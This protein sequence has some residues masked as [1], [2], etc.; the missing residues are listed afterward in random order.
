MD[1]VRLWG[2]KI[3][4]RVPVLG[5]LMRKIYSWNCPHQELFCADFPNP[6]GYSCTADSNGDFIEALSL[7]GAA[8]MEIGTITPSGHLDKRKVASK[9]LNEILHNLQKTPKSLIIAANI[10]KDVATGR[11]AAKY[12]YEKS[13][14]LLYD[15]VDMFVVNLEGQTP[16]ETIDLQDIDYLG[17]I[18][19]HLLSLRLYYDGYK[20]ILI[21]INH[22]AHDYAIQ[23]IL[24]Y[25]MKYGIDGVIAD[26]NKL[27]DTVALVKKIKAISG[28]ILPIVASGGV[29]HSSHAFSLIEAG[30]S[31]ISLNSAFH[32][33]GSHCIN[34]I[35]RGLYHRK[36][37]LL[38][39]YVEEDTLNDAID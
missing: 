13:F 16:Q 30:A 31:L 39:N 17:D 37:G 1:K 11:E 7:T 3:I 22:T 33:E 29:L 21:K 28:N 4:S 10:G 38:S 2:L 14:S 12:D 26:A 18:L 27:E 9:N 15:Y 19:D 35:L 8:F 25:S 23:D 34:N 24:E 20:P 5:P 6:L 36:H 32:V